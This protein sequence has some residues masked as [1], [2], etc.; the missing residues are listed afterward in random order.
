[1]DI[2]GD[3]ILFFETKIQGLVMGRSIPANETE[4]IIYT[5][6]LPKN[7]KASEKNRWKKYM[8]TKNQDTAI[9]EAKK[10]NS[11]Q[12]F[13]KIEIK[14]KIMDKKKGRNVD[15][16]LKIFENSPTAPIFEAKSVIAIIAICGILAF[17]AT[18]YFIQLQ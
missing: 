12:K 13:Q 16:T 4:Y 14:K 9:K 5:F 18:Y 17:T 6:E 2:A 15:V 1:M 3:G 10:L 7:N 11:S 8:S